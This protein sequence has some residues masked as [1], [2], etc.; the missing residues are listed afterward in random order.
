M[1]T[2]FSL[3]LFV[4]SSYS[5]SANVLSEEC[6]KWPYSPTSVSALKEFNAALTSGQVE[7]TVRVSLMKS[8]LMASL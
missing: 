7:M 8:V 6:T 3:L 1:S 4:I 5:S 2:I